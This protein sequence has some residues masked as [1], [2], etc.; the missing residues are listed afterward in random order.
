MRPAAFITALGASAALLVAGL[1]LPTPAR[2]ESAVPPLRER[3]SITAMDGMVLFRPG[4]LLVGNPTVQGRPAV[5]PLDPSRVAELPEQ[6]GEYELLSDGC[7]DG[8]EHPG[9]AVI[10]GGVFTRGD[11]GGDGRLEQVRVQRKAPM[12]AP[13][14][15]VS[16][17]G[18]LVGRG[19]LPVPAVPCRALIAE[20]EPEGQPVLMIVW[21]SRGAESTTV[22]VTI[23]ELDE[24]PATGE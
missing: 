18:R 23:F 4:E 12:A 11:M 14:V 19:E 3:A 1:A 15:M 24:A 5:R 17:D 21:T 13:E 7:L 20:A 6:P 9:P 8:T 2:A 22:G 10:E 16:R